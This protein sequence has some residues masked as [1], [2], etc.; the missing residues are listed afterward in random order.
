MSSWAATCFLK[1]ATAATSSSA[2]SSPESHRS[3]DSAAERWARSRVQRQV[4]R[5]LEQV[6]QVEVHREIRD[7]PCERL[8]FDFRIDLGRF[9]FEF[10]QDPRRRLGH[11]DFGLESFGQLGLC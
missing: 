9:H 5:A 6:S 10:H 1:S 3:E 11:V 4:R 2:G 7:G 8:L